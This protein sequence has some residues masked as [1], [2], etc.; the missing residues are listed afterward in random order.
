MFTIVLKE[1]G[2]II[3]L[4]NIDFK[5]TREEEW[6]PLRVEVQVEDF[7]GLDVEAYRFIE[8][9]L[10]ELSVEGGKIIV[11]PETPVKPKPPPALRKYVAGR[12][13][14]AL[15]AYITSVDE[16]CGISTY[17]QFLSA[18]VD[19]LFPARCYRNISEIDPF[20]LVHVQH[21][22][23][24][25]P[26]VD[27]VVGKRI[28]R[29]YKVCTWHTAMRNPGAL[30]DIYHTVDQQ[31]DAHV[32]HNYLAKK[33]MS[34]YVNKPIHVIPHGSLLFNPLPRD[35]ARKKLG[36][37]LDRDIV[38]CFGFAAESKGFEEICWM[39]GLFKDPKTVF[40]ISAAPHG[41]VT[42]HSKRVLQRLKIQAPDN[43]HILG[44]F[45]RE[46]EINLYAS[47]CD[48][49]LFNYKTPGF[50]A[51]ASGALHRVLAA[52]KPVVCSVDNRLIELEDGHHALKF[53]KGDIEH[54]K[55]CLEMVLSDKDLASEL[56]KNVRGLAEQTRWKNVAQK[57]V[58]LYE[59][60]VG[61]LFGPEYY[62]EAYF[63]TASKVYYTPEGE[64]KKWGYLQT[65]TINWHGWADVAD[66]LKELF[67]PQKVLD[68]GTGTGG[69]VHY[70][71]QAGLDARGC[72]FSLY[73][74]THPF[75]MAK[76]RVDL[77]EARELSYPDDSF[78]LVCA[79]D[80]MEHIYEEDLPEVI[81]E[82]QRVSSRYIFYNIGTT[83]KNQRGVMVLE[84]GKFPHRDMLTTSVA[85]HVTVIS[86]SEWRKKLSNE[87]WRLRDDLAVR[88]RRRVIDKFR[89][90][91][92]QFRS[93][94]CIVVTEKC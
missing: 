42:D 22:F 72:D 31:Y 7:A 65:S 92:P 32:V 94:S 13:A 20:C 37:P 8:E 19:K 67:H 33:Y 1:K 78:D 24:L 16:K 12:K 53:R 39:A 3:A 93:W 38:F 11:F 4:A 35:Q 57:H 58:E 81:K 2:R 83:M 47:A 41:I 50:I 82:L 25:F 48:C 36:L 90:S 79:L 70:A 66:G 75:G 86:P 14:P 26:Y 87:E 69:L 30:L 44:R 43:V 89:K 61:D 28:G 29:S 76:G 18:E 9:G 5:G 17:S 63:D 59:D 77:E 60:L 84:K 15:V 6:D 85:G 23:G 71:V 52:G 34:A 55:H 91:W 80:L 68:V 62:D 73:A 27:E 46:E 54:A 49:L 45:L 10:D 56:G 88:F 64:E 74:V 21:E 51:S 40:A